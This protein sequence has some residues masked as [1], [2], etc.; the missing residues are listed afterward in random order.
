[1]EIKDKTLDHLRACYRRSC[2]GLPRREVCPRNIR[3]ARPVLK[4]ETPEEAAE[5][6][7]DASA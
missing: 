7:E 2:A 3:R 6:E 1:M 4:E 5:D